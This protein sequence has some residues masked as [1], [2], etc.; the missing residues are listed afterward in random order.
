M[1][2]GASSTTP[3]SPLLAMEKKPDVP[4][5]SMPGNK[6]SQ[7][8]GTLGWAVRCGV[9][10]GQALLTLVKKKKLPRPFTKNLLGREKNWTKTISLAT[11]DLD[12]GFPLSEALRHLERFLPKYVIPAVKEAERN[13]R[14]QEVLPI[15]SEQT[16]RRV[17]VF[18]KRVSATIFPSLLVAICL[19]LGSVSI[20]QIAMVLI[21]SREIPLSLVAVLP[22]FVRFCV[23]ISLSL[24]LLIPSIFILRFIY[25]R[26]PFSRAVFETLLIHLPW[27]G[28]D[29]KRMAILDATSAMAGLV[30]AGAGLREAAEIAAESS[31]SHWM[32]KRLRLLATEIEAGGKWPDAWEKMGLGF[33]FLDWLIRNAAA[34]ENPVEGFS[35]ITA[36]LR[37]DISRFTILFAKAMDF[38][39]TLFNAALVASI[40]IVSLNMLFSITRHCAETT[41]P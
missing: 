27:I 36:L 16:A 2:R 25:K 11:E 29:L 19:F 24:A 21:S 13:N 23:L 12:N 1:I 31:R 15:L 22:F 14:L 35:S 20:V 40:V 34:R 4:T 17:A 39:A 6:A 37:N 9:P 18:G 32:G 26:E 38:S 30:A 7:I 28:R 5:Y 33:P 41:F 3:T 8:L 10:L